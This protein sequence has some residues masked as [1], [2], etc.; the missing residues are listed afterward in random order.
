MEDL[1]RVVK[2]TEKAVESTAEG[3]PDRAM[4]LT[5][6]GSALRRRS[7]RTRSKEDLDHTIETNEQAACSDVAPPW[8]RLWAASVC[9]DILLNQRMLKHATPIIELA[10]HLLPLRSPCQL[11]RTDAQFN[12]LQFTNLTARAISLCLE[13]MKDLYKTL[14]LLELGRGILANLPL[15][16]RS[17]ISSLHTKYPKVVERFQNLRDQ[18]DRP[19]DFEKLEGLFTNN[20]PSIVST[21]ISTQHSLCNEFNKLLFTHSLSGRIRELLEGSFR[22]GVT[23]IGL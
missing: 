9:V 22:N 17:D 15:E 14:Q 23:L 4:Y 16:I 10:V 7:E 3:H 12:V 21:K 6:L 13:H 11:K 20:Q 8:I 18:I 19:A 5:N 2:V 1:D